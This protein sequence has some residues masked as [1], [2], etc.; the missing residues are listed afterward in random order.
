MAY[1]PGTS[2][3]Y[4]GDTCGYKAGSQ[5]ISVRRAPA[6]RGEPTKYRRVTVPT[7]KPCGEPARSGSGCKARC[8]EHRN[9]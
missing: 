6:Y 4:Y 5:N 1:L 2:V 9:A 7:G 3:T 8:W